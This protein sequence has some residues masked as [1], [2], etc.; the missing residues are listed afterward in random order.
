MS[1]LTI[2][3]AADGSARCIYTD[4]LP[5]ADLGQLDVRRASHVEFN[6]D[7]QRWEVRF[8]DNPAAVVFSAPSR[9]E[10]IVWEIETLQARLD[11]EV[12]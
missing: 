8:T 4:A 12:Q 1:N 2:N 11:S 7:A 3:I 9:A 6:S 10:C 5:L